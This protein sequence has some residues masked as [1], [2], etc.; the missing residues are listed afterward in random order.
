[1]VKKETDKQSFT[2]VVGTV[3]NFIFFNF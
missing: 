2:K 3:N 1:M